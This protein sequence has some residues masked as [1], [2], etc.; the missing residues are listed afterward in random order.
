MKASTAKDPGSGN[1]EMYRSHF[2]FKLDAKRSISKGP[3]LFE[4]AAKP[5]SERVHSVSVFVFLDSLSASTLPTEAMY[6]ANTRRFLTSHHCQG[7]L[8]RE[9][10]CGC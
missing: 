6:E 10:R 1:Q 9:E 3:N 5:M 7:S 4:T 8:A 2:A